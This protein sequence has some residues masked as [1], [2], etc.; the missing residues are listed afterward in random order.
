LA[1]EQLLIMLVTR[2]GEGENTTG[3]AAV[4]YVKMK[5]KIRQ[6]TAKL[7]QNNY[8]EINNDL[9][10]TCFRS[11]HGEYLTLFYRLRPPEKT[12]ASTTCPCWLAEWDND[13]Y[14]PSVEQ[15]RNCRISIPLLREKCRRSVFHCS[16]VLKSIYIIP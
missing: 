11:A 15:K 7:F 16:T 13:R 1:T 4:V 10:T 9:Q 14:R 6:Q 3:W 5:R 12:A 8:Y 2:R